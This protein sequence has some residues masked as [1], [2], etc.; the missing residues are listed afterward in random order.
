MSINNL[1]SFIFACFSVPMLKNGKT[2]TSL[3]F[4]VILGLLSIITAQKTE[5]SSTYIGDVI[6]SIVI[7]PQNPEIIY[8]TTQQELY[9]SIDRGK[10]WN[11]VNRFHVSRNNLTIDPYN[12]A[13][14][15]M[16]AHGL[17]N[18]NYAGIIKSVDSGL[19]WYSLIGF[20]NLVKSSNGNILVD[21][22]NSSIVY[23]CF[24]GSMLT[25]AEGSIYKS[26]DAGVNWEKIVDNLGTYVVRYYYDPII[27]AIS[28]QKPSVMYAGVTTRD[29]SR[30]LKS[31][32]DGKTWID[33]D[34]VD[35]PSYYLNDF[36]VSP[37]D[38]NTIYAVFRYRLYRST[39]GGKNWKELKNN[40]Y[41]QYGASHSSIALTNDPNIIYIKAGG[42]IYRSANGGK[43]WKRPYSDKNRISSD[44]FTVDPKNHEIIYAGSSYG[45]HI[46]TDS[47]RTWSDISNG[48]PRRDLQKE[49][50]ERKRLLQSC[51]IEFT[52]E[53]IYQ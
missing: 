32:D 35:Y 1:T 21:P 41:K 34:G 5:A 48:L 28:R 15:Y 17:N 44:F 12:A 26:T 53:C 22:N 36:V 52:F 33:I 40:L 27:L 13:V 29:S 16:E 30:I 47:G 49:T 25:G 20:E 9:K 18:D 10:K 39:D 37:H 7:D 14:M 24:G 42:D 11:L 8:A 31:V 19:S 6:Q 43:T 23:A 2:K 46:S 38:S 4:V 3:L 45:L 51:A 50:E